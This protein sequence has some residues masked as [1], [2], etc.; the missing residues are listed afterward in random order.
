LSI[1]EGYLIQFIVFMV[2][3]EIESALGAR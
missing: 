2:V 3:M 1:K